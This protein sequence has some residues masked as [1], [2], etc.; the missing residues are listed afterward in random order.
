MKNAIALLALLAL[1]Q[2]TT[3]VQTKET[4]AAATPPQVIDSLKAGNERFATGRPQHRNLLK[5]AKLT[6]SGQHPL[7]AVVS[8]IDSR[9]SS[10]LVV[11]Q[12]IGDIFNARVAGNVINDDILGSLEFACA[13]AGSKAIVVV[14]HTSCG[15]VK[16]AAKGVQLEHLTGL[17]EK[18]QPAIKHTKTGGDDYVDR[19]AV[20]NV[21]QSV[22]T[23]RAK[24][25]TLRKLEKEGKIA[26]IGAMYHLD[27]GR[28]EFLH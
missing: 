20:E 28:V 11:D 9:T 2:C 24:S 8:C 23:I 1:T 3:T 4:Q 21:K 15:A 13:A 22:A 25:T 18:I 26:I 10:E 16:G 14:G 5:Q 27:T 19:V 7:A 6:V 12:G 17:L